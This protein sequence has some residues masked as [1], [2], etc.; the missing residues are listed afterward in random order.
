MDML[1]IVPIHR[2]M[3]AQREGKSQAI[4]ESEEGWIAKVLFSGCGDLIHACADIIFCYCIFPMIDILAIRDG[5]GIS[6]IKLEDESLI[7][8]LRIK[9]LA[10]RLV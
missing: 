6:Q 2:H 7:F 8:S 5:C 3:P 4:G 9:F 1:W 10:S